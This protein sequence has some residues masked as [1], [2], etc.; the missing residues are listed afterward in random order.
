VRFEFK[1]RGGRALSAISYDA[2]VLS[3]VNGQRL[4]EGVEIASLALRLAAPDVGGG[5]DAQG[6]ES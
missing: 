3:P 6:D 1:D 4:L 5:D 2:L